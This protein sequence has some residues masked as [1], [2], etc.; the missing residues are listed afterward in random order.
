MSPGD[1]GSTS[2]T[3]NPIGTVHS[4]FETP[5]QV[6]KHPS[7]VVDAS[8]TVEICDAYVDGLAS[9]E[10]FSHVLLVVHLHL[11][12]E[13]TMRCD[14]PFVD[15]RRPGIFATRGPRRPNPIGVSPVQLTG[16]SDGVLT[17]EDLDLVDGTPVLDVKP[18]V[19][20]PGS[21]EGLEG[22]WIEADTDQSFGQ[23]RDRSE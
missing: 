21:L 18:F 12:G 16:V 1:A 4:P 8:G 19:P 6:P 10:G 9:I 20:K 13:P 3:Y 2:V 22:G 7:E 11:A 23:F 17:V 14:P 5:E 15:D